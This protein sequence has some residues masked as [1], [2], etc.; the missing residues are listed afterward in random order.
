MDFDRVRQFRELLARTNQLRQFGV[1]ASPSVTGRWIRIASNR[2]KHVYNLLLLNARL[3]DPATAIFA[4]KKLGQQIER[5]SGR[6]KTDAAKIVLAAQHLQS[7]K[8]NAE[9][10]ATFVTGEGMQFIDD[11]KFG[12]GEM[13]RVTLLRQQNGQRCGRGDEKG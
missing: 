13:L 6:R 2:K 10:G 8:R 9:I 5:C 7:L 11:H 1:E 4:N 12:V 3:R